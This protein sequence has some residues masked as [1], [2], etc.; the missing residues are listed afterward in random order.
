MRYDRQVRNAKLMQASLERSLAKPS[1][2]LMLGSDQIS[3]R[4]ECDLCTRDPFKD[5]RLGTRACRDKW[6]G[7][8]H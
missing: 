8:E 7:E 6:I 2:L 5:T 4:H 1:S 3:V